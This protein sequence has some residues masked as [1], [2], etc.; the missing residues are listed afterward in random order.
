MAYSH[1]AGDVTWSI[2]KTLTVTVEVEVTVA[3]N[4][5]QSRMGDTTI[6]AGVV[7][8]DA[9]DSIRIDSV[10][11]DTDKIVFDETTLQKIS[12]ESVKVI[13]EYREDQARLQS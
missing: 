1:S 5:H 8:N 6:P 7:A 13:R 11:V 3:L 2:T 4:E 9:L 10:Y 12:K